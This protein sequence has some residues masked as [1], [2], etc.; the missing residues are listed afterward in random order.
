MKSI[1]A[2]ALFLACFAC[3]LQLNGQTPF[4]K[5]NGNATQLIV[6]GKP[7]L[8][9]AAEVN[10]SSGSNI[11]YMDKTLKSLHESNFNSVLAS[12]SWEIIEP[13]EGVFDF[14]SV[15]ELIRVA[16]A[17]D[18]K[19]GI[20]WF[21]SWKNSFSPY[22]PMWVLNDT[23]RFV[24]IKDAKGQNTR[25]LTP[26]CNATRDA[27][28][29][30]FGELMKH[31][32]VVD[33][34]NT[35]LLLQ[36][37]NE[38]GVIH[39]TRDLSDEAGKAFNSAV[40]DEL[41][42]YMVKNKKTLETELKTAWESNGSKTK[43][44]WNE[45]FG[46]GDNTDMFFMAWYYASYLNKVAE[47]GKKAFNLPMYAN[48]WM[49]QPRPN[50]GKP[51]NYPS[52]GPVLAVLDIWKAGAPSID[53][54]APDLYGSDFKNQVN[55]FHRFDNPLFIAETSTG[56][57]QAVWSFAEEDAICFSPFGI[58]TRGSVMANEY[59]IIKQMM[60]VITQYQG[61]G[62]MAGIFKYRADSSAGR[63]FKLNND[64]KISVNYQRVMQRPAA[65]G[66]AGNPP[67][68]NAG[69]L[70]AQ[71]T[72]VPASYGLFIQTGENEFIVAGYNI[73][74][75][76]TSTNPKK[77]VWLKD[78]WEGGYE[79]GVWIP[80]TLYNGDEAGFLRG[81]NPSY[82]IRGYHSTPA[83]PAIFKFKVAVYNK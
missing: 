13:S 37:E 43:G 19:L 48:T 65:T 33:K 73:S 51:G 11:P 32:G 26:L 75:T 42:Q 6:N 44:T 67:A 53:I 52:G 47:A 3:S 64:V 49:S 81:D 4:L 83:E 50:P 45:V 17:N 5:K 59:G 66:T 23:K 18:M 14:K 38:V 7:F 77:E 27:D 31:I 58:D 39:Q 15:D 56:E 2:I 16:R 40:P 78:A 74:V 82:A 46:Q 61:T 54:I 68:Q 22:A 20:L 72:Q 57:G 21:A 41:I 36:I 10:N 1:K 30:A 8:M 69:N 55:Y 76:A 60:P 80:K 63:D 28:A 25:I 70:A 71:Q 9:L 24:R 29:R 62:K 34:D 79:N 12:V 35:V